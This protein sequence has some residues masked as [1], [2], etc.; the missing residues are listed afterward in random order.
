MLLPL[1]LIELQYNR[2]WVRLTNEQNFQVHPPI[3]VMHVN[4]LRPPLDKLNNAI[5][6]KT[7]DNS[8]VKYSSE[9][10]GTIRRSALLHG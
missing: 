2:T 1:T 9:K 3:V 6:D 4:Y 5:A 7:S 8:P 10:Y